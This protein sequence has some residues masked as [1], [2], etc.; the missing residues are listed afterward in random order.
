MGFIGVYATVGLPRPDESVKIAFQMP[1]IYNSW[2]PFMRE[3][4]IAY[5]RR[6]FFRM[7]TALR[8]TPPYHE[9]K[10]V[11]AAQWSLIGGTMADQHYV[12]LQNMQA[13]H[14]AEYES[15]ESYAS[16]N[17]ALIPANVSGIR[18]GSDSR[19]TVFYIY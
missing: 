8:F 12:M 18:R 16:F 6:T 2:A 19:R 1:M 10:E 7:A 5:H 13:Q 11:T 3:C 4:A 9:S 14:D 15:Y 17:R